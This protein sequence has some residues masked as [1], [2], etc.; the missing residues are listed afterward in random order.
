MQRWHARNR[1][2]DDIALV[3]YNTDGTLDTTFGTGNYGAV[4]TAIGS[5][6][7]DNAFSLAIQSNGKI[8]VA[9]DSFNSS[10]DDFAEGLGGAEP[11]SAAGQRIKAMLLA[12]QVAKKAARGRTDT[13]KEG[14]E[15]ESK[16]SKRKRKT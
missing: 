6:G 15:G 16:N 12:K 8:L 10:D 7:N 13:E 5:S 11:V 9:C 2:R 4:T 3:R 1:H 14:N